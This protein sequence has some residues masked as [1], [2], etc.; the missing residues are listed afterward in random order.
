EPHHQ[1]ASLGL[2]MA[3]FAGGQSD[4]ALAID[5]TLLTE[6]TDYSEANLLAAEILVRGGHFTDAETYL[7]KIRHTGQKFMP[8]VH[9]SLGQVYFATGRLPQALAELKLG[10]ASDDDGS[11]HYQLGRIYQKM[12]DKEK[13]EE[14][15]R[16]SKQLRDQ[17]DDRVDLAPQ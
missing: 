12:G 2:A 10:L 6:A 16:V 5:K 9:T 14:A 8:R 7:K 13:A 11:T 17:S 3:L 15:F 1:S 4:E